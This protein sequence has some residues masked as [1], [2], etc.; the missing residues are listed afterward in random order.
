MFIYLSILYISKMVE[1]YEG[2]SKK[3]VFNAGVAQVQRIDSLQKAINASR[4]NPLMRNLEVGRFNY[5]IMISSN[6]ALLFEAWSKLS[7]EEQKEG[8]RIKS[9]IHE[10]IEFHPVVSQ[11]NNGELIV[12]KE[13]YKQFMELIDIYEKINKTLLEKHDLNSPSRDEDD[14]L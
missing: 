14:E 11:K 5:E 1:E 3:S 7:S 12:I 13:N 9:I 2:D 10:F 6:D 8:E 4:F